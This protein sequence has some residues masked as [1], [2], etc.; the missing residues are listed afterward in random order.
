MT[1]DTTAWAL[2]KH[3]KTGNNNEKKQKRKE[4]KK[5]KKW[6][7]L[8]NSFESLAERFFLYFHFTCWLESFSMV[9]ND[10]YS[11]WPKLIQRI[12]HRPSL[13]LW[14]LSSWPGRYVILLLLSF[15]W[16]CEYRIRYDRWSNGFLLLF[17]TTLNS[18]LT[19]QIYRRVIIEI[20]RIAF[21][22]VSESY[23]SCWQLN[24]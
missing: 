6:K 12:D 2:H 16:T 11:R 21:I 24:H 15:F 13:V 22:F 9:W 23:F 10:N 7:K 5:K 14:A 8:R 19:Q 3:G 18:I 20:N 17:T 1:N 4:I